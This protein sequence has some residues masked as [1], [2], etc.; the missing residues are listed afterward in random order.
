VKTFVIFA[1]LRL[2]G[3]ALNLFLFVLIIM[4]SMRLSALALAAGLSACAS[5]P[6]RGPVPPALAP[7]A[8][9]A[10][11]RTR[12]EAVRTVSA[13]LS[14]RT[15]GL[16]PGG[17]C[18][19]ALAIAYPDRLRLKAWRGAFPLFDFALAGGAFEVRLPREDRTIRGSLDDAPSGPEDETRRRFYRILASVLASGR[20]D[21]PSIVLV[22]EEE[23]RIDRLGVS[24][25][26]LWVDRR[27]LDVLRHRL[28]PVGGDA[29]EAVFDDYREAAPGIRWP[30]RIGVR[31]E[32][33]RPFA[34]SMRF[35]DVALNVPLP[36]E[37]LG[38][39]TQRN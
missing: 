39:G 5:A 35:H 18:D 27:T 4:M 3:S 7:D 34:V 16:D 38:V 10:A 30:H 13:S 31:G 22:Q 33:A 23:Y 15:E 8:L 37:A 17:R 36:P 9:L 6:G 28:E 19:A 12:A 29:A 32:G 2:R 21:E 11:L 24:R 25:Q 1:T 14:L 26:S 20:R